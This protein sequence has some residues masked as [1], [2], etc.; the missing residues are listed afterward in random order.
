MPAGNPRVALVLDPRFDGREAGDR[1]AQA[2]TAP[3]LAVE[4]ELHRG[5]ARTEDE[6]IPGEQG[7]AGSDPL[8][9]G[10]DPAG[11]V[12]HPAPARF[13]E[14]LPVQVLDLELHRGLAPPGR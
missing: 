10:L 14:T 3:G 9:H 11:I 6:Q 2:P 12:A 5:A 1:G 4:G 13:A 8:D 7:D